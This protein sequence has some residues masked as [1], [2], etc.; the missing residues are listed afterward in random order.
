[1]KISFG[2][3]FDL[4]LQ[5]QSP[6]HNSSPARRQKYATLDYSIVRQVLA[7]VYSKNFPQIVYKYTIYLFQFIFYHLHVIQHLISK[8]LI[9]GYRSGILCLHFQTQTGNVLSFLVLQIAE[10]FP[11]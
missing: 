4:I 7:T 11:A 8:P 1:M 2:K 9:E 3:T 10:K 5:N 6:T